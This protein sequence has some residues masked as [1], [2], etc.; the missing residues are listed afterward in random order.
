M[1]AAAMRSVYVSVNFENAFIFQ[2]LPQ[3]PGGSLVAGAG[4]LSD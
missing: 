2:A 3:K 1:W 4:L